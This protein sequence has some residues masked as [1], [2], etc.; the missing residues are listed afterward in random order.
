MIVC[1]I[2]TS[3]GARFSVHEDEESLRV[4]LIDYF[5]ECLAEGNFQLADDTDL[6]DAIEA[7]EESEDVSW[8]DVPILASAPQRGESV[9]SA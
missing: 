2:R 3:A 5:N 1:H 7:I 9:R 4:E 8:E 6:D